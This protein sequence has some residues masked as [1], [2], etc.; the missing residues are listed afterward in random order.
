[1]PQGAQGQIEYPAAPDTGGP[2]FQPWDSKMTIS[3]TEA[4]MIRI[5]VDRFVNLKE[6]TNRKSLV[7]QF[8][9]YVEVDQLIRFAMLSAVDND[10]NLAPRSLG[11]EFSGNPD[12]LKQAKQSVEIVLQALQN[13]YEV[14]PP[15]KQITQNDVLIEAKKTCDDATADVIQL[16]LYFLQEFPVFDSYGSQGG[17]PIPGRM[18]HMEWMVISERIVTIEATNAWDDH[19]R[20]RKANLEPHTEV[21][22]VALSYAKPQELSDVLILISHS[23]KD[24]GLAESLIDL[25]RA[26]LPLSAKEIV[27]SSVDGYRL[28]LGVETNEQLRETVISVRLLVGLLTPSSLS[29]SYVLFELGARWGADLPMIPLW[30]GVHGGQVEGPIKGVNAASCG[31][32]KQLIQFVE[33]VGELLG[34]EVESASS[35]LE[36]ARIVKQK[37]DAI[38]APTRVTAPAERENMLFEETVYWKRK[39][40]EREGP[41]CPHCYEANDKILHLKPGMT[42]GSFSCPSCREVFHTRDFVFPPHKNRLEGI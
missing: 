24:A 6:C 1:M 10:G 40:G 34:L 32:E 33:E 39:N 30:A 9:S 15:R 37:S 23:S 2:A 14:T 38:V 36:K 31:N 13:L 25:L 17:Q 3:E 29:S 28:P 19:V 20:H 4:K 26:A 18:P 8:K 27:C 35:Y 22:E 21:T 12:A 41:Y 16:G 42:R 11:F 5:V 7:T